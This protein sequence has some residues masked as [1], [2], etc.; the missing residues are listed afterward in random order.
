MALPASSPSAAPNEPNLSFEQSSA[1]R[2]DHSLDSL[3]RAG[4]LRA[5]TFATRIDPK[6]E[7]APSYLLFGG[8]QYLICATGP[9]PS[10]PS[11]E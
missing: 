1:S 4:A 11:K 8:G 3:P 10:R 2:G 7:V 6:P 5:R 9:R